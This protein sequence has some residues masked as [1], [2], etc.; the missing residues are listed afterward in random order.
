MHV[1]NSVLSLFSAGRTL[2]SQDKDNSSQMS[3]WYCQP[4]TL[5]EVGA[6]TD[7]ISC[8]QQIT[9][10]YEYSAFDFASSETRKALKSFGIH[11]DFKSMS[12][13][14]DPSGIAVELKSPRHK[15]RHLNLFAVQQLSNRA[16]KLRQ[17]ARGSIHASYPH[18]KLP[19][20]LPVLRPGWLL[21]DVLSGVLHAAVCILF[22]FWPCAFSLAVPLRSPMVT[23]RR[24]IGCQAFILPPA[25]L[26]C[27]VGSLKILPWPRARAPLLHHLWAPG[28]QL[29][30][31]A[32]HG[33]S[34]LHHSEPS[35]GRQHEVSGS[36]PSA[37]ALRRLA[38]PHLPLTLL[39]VHGWSCLCLPVS[40][41]HLA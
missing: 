1:F 33:F 10:P 3:E 16:S 11:A 26:S 5:A 29:S 22:A 21:V 37:A 28:V 2:H 6:L 7:A 30:A 36:E 39:R 8:Y 15:P 12:K 24:Q 40:H 38:C 18:Y 25:S 27:R 19:H 32:L 9:R 13:D 34:S 31:L 23:S 35:S 41:P 20:V 14:G 4:L 17:L